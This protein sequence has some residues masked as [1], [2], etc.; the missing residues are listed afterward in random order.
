MGKWI[1]GERIEFVMD[2]RGQS[3]W[4]AMCGQIDSVLALRASQSRSRSFSRSLVRNLS[5]SSG[6]AALSFDALGAARIRRRPIVPYPR[7]R[8]DRYYQ[9]C[10]ARGKSLLAHPRGRFNPA[11]STL[12]CPA[13]RP[14]AELS[15]A[16]HE[17]YSGCRGRRSDAPVRVRRRRR[18]RARCWDSDRNG[19]NYSMKPPAA[20]DARP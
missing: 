13:Q 9:G 20:G 16:R 12:V 8:A 19:G 4:Q 2:R 3:A 7:I 1:A 18:D 10:R 6:L 11:D 15:A 17:S 14:N 5:R